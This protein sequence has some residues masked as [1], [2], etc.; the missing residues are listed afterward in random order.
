MRD[1]IPSDPNRVATDHTHETTDIMPE[2]RKEQV[3]ADGYQDVPRARGSYANSKLP[4]LGPSVRG[5]ES[6]GVV[7]RGRER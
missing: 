5:E 4:H 3:T 2:I 1:K 7:V 6:L